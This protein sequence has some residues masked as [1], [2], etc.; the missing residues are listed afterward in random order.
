MEVLVKDDV[1][2]KDKL[3]EVFGY[4]QFRGNQEAIINN[5]INGNNTFVIMPTGAGKSLCYQLPALVLPGTAIVISPLIAL[6]K[7]QV[8]QLNAF[9]VNAQFL[10]STL[11]KAEMNKVKKETI[12]GEVKL[13][14][15]APESLTKEETLD[16][17]QKAKISFV[18]IDEAHCISEWGHD[19][20]P[21]YRKIR[22]I[23]DGIGN[24]PIIALTATATPKVQL[25]IQK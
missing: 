25:D 16:F 24:L 20:R 1:I 3:K 10:N 2:L 19:F 23:I 5:I 17:L 21:E 22:G 11:T 7:N 13:L 14:Y 6:M 15:V 8:D 18:A 12:S 4:N 9:G